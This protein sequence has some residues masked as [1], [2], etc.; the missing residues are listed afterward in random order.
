MAAA[1][2]RLWRGATLALPLLAYLAALALIAY[3]WTMSPA[4]GDSTVAVRTGYAA[5]Y[6]IGLLLFAAAAWRLQAEWRAHRT[7][8][9]VRAAKA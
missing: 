2:T 5:A 3:G 4:S 7:A 8:L 9:G 6:G 1:P